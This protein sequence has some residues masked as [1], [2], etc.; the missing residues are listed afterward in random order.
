MA[1]AL[2][3]TYTA[4]ARVDG[5]VERLRLTLCE[6]HARELVPLWPPHQVRVGLPKVDHCARCAALRGGER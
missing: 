4:T 2:V 1:L 3:R 5:A 6:R